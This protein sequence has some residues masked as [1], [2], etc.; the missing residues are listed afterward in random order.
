MLTGAIPVQTWKVWRDGFAVRLFT[1]RFNVF[2]RWHQHLWFR[3]CREF[4]GI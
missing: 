1:V 3:R 2:A 4:E